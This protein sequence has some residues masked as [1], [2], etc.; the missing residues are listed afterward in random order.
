MKKNLITAL[1]MT[2]VTT[3]LLGII[4]PLIVTALSQVLFHD[5]A[6]GQLIVSNGGVVGSRIIGQPFV[7]PQY[8]HSR[9][10]AAGNGYD[11]ANSGGTN[12][13]PTNQKLIDRVKQDAATAQSENSA[14][15]VP[16]DLVTTSASGLDPD[17]TPA[18]AE[19]QI[20]RI[21]QQRHLTD[22][23]VRQLVRKYTQPRQWGYLGEPRVNVL[24]LNLALDQTAGK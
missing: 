4:Y 5:K 2:V 21:A 13:G 3:V 24:E 16:V 17:I 23:A 8:F 9:P 20:A 12:L 1:L 10:S 6:N 22:D 19:F 7:G 14:Q 18:A 15:P 11:A